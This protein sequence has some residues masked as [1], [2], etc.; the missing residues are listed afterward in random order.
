MRNAFTQAC[1]DHP[2]VVELSIIR[3]NTKTASAQLS[4]PASL[5]F[6]FAHFYH[7]LLHKAWVI[8]LFVI[9]GLSA[10]IAYLTWAPKIYES[11]AVIEV[12]QES[13]RVNN[14]QDFNPGN[15]EDINL[16]AVLKT[17][18]EAFLSETLLLRVVKINQLDKDPSFAPPKEDGSAYLDSELVGKFER[19]VKVALRRGTRLIDVTVEDRDPQRAQQLAESMVKEFVD[20][21]FEK[22]LGLSENAT[23]YLRKESD[24]LKAKLQNAEQAVQKFREDNNA[25]SLED[26]QNITVEKLKELNMQVTQ[27]KSE[28]L[29]LEADVA[30]IKQGKVK[31]PEELLALPSVAAL[32]IVSSLRQALADKES[33]FKADSQLRGLRDSLDRTLVNVGNMVVKSYEASKAT[34]AKL[35]TALQEQEQVALGLNKIAIPYNALVREVETDRALYESVLTRMKVTNVAKGI[36]ENNIHVIESP[37]LAAKPA[38]PSK[39]K[40]LA[41]AL[42]GSFVLGCGLVF[43]L[44]LAD[45][46]IRSVDHVERISRLPVLTS[47]PESRRK[48]LDK[49]SVLN[50]DPGSYEAEAFRSL[51]TALSFLGPDKDCKTVLFTSANPAEGKSYCSLNY[52]VALAHTGLRTLLIDA[53]MR[54]PNLSKA[55]LASTKGPG[56]TDCLTRRATVA[57]SC[58]PT[59]VENLFIL[60]AGERASKPA[61]LLASCDFAGMLREA[62]LQFDRVVLDSAPINAV[63][64]T[65]LIAKDIQSVCFVVRAAKTPGRAIV[66]ACSLLAQTG[67][68]PDGVVFNRIPR[69]SRDRY[70]FSAY[71]GEYANAGAHGG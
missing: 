36:W 5:T 57:D 54:R 10:A 63:S 35:T 60:P 1:L 69:R 52:A 50:S 42:V 41:L 37:L 22:T 53:D 4:E 16:P 38:K 68:N 39:L 56:L 19:K 9:L 47:V 64:D 65:Q 3:V 44:D 71:A 20:Q 48:D 23:D 46:S 27:A 62:L 58:R 40:I 30:V 7:L 33:R 61:E 70:Y 26:K 14:I 67:S 17:I 59:G 31:T 45:S 6:D 8:I 13:P 34:E 32:P 2:L 55:L 66:R 24:R 15:T 49:V 12:E 51:R 43:G 18:E 21:S 25:V 29:K 11:R 28:R